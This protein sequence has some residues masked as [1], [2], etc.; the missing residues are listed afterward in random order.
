M[1][2]RDAARAATREK[3]L[4]AASALFRQHGFTSTTV[5]EIASEAGVSV[6]S[7]MGVGEKNDLLVAIF[8]EAIA[9]V[10]DGRSS[11]PESAYPSAAPVDRIMDIVSPFVKI[12]A[13]HGELAREYAAVLTGGRHTSVVYQELAATLIH[14][15]STVLAQSG[16]DAEEVPIAANTVYLAYIGALF[17]AAGVGMTDYRGLDK[18][19]RPVFEFIIRTQGGI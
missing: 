17:V 19:M 1:S 5:R 16:F 3:V 6:G 2:A 9:R 12:F 11:R 13:E 18:Q 7:V 8:D 14:E 15:I 4:A 10:H